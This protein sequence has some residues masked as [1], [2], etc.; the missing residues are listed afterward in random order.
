MGVVFDADARAEQVHLV[1]Q[2]AQF[3]RR[4]GPF[5]VGPNDDVVDGRGLPRL[6]QVGRAGKQHHGAVR[7]HHQAL[8]EAEA[9]GV[10]AGQPIHAFLGEQEDRVELLVGHFDH[11]AVPARI[12]FGALEMQGHQRSSSTI[13][14]ISRP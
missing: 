3:E 2:I 8:K 7:L 4:I 9:E 12:V 6:A 11:Q 10:V 13:D 5:A 14:E 1:E